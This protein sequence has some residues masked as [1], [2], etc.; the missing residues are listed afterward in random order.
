MGVE[1]SLKMR[2]QKII[3]QAG[4]ASRRAAEELIRSGAVTVNGQI[5]R[6]MGSQADPEKDH[7]K[8][9]GKLITTREPLAYVILNKPLGV[10]TTARDPEG[11]PTV[12]SL[13]SGVRHRLFPVGRLD[14]DSEGLLLMTNDGDLAYRMM[15]PR[16]GVPKTY[17][18]R[19]K[20][21]LTDDQIARLERGVVLSDGRTSSCQVK[22]LRKGD[23]NSWIAVTIREG[24]KR[25]VRRMIEGL[26][27]RVLRLRR[28]NIGPLELG[29]LESGRFRFLNAREIAALKR[30]VDE[31]S[32]APSEMK[33]RR[34][35][36]VGS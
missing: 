25:Q 23:A 14:F 34:R 12:V 30:Y 11:R 29:D 33:G 32:D 10:V 24:R 5:V 26:G 21:V 7:V 3:A 13:L 6:E 36:A 27:N 17:Q 9:S 8:V 22:K 19:V 28:T 15:H 35:K 1:I 4:V 18:V 16:Y 20:G 2:L 31:A